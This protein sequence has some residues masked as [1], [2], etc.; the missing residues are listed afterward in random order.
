MLARVLNHHIPHT[1]FDRHLTTKTTSYCTA[2]CCKDTTPPPPDRFLKARALCS[3]NGRKSAFVSSRSFRRRSPFDILAPS[4]SWSD[5]A[6]KNRSRGCGMSCNPMVRT[7]CPRLLKAYQLYR[8]SPSVVPMN[9]SRSMAEKV[10]FPA[11]R[12]GEGV[13]TKHRRV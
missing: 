13:D 4:S 2:V 6:L 12:R 7:S 9:G 5:R 1:P 3:K 10:W 11:N 8:S